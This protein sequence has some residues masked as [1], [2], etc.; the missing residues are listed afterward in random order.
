[1]ATAKQFAKFPLNLGGGDAAGD[2]PMDVLSDSVRETLHTSGGWT[3]NQT[4]NEVKADATGEL[5]TAGGYTALGQLLAS[6][7]YIQ[8]SLRSKFDA[9]DVTWP[10]TTFTHRYAAFWDDTITV[11]ADPLM[12]WIDNGGDVTTSA[13]DLVYQFHATDGIWYFDVT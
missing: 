10:A 2:G 13:T 5:T 3:P 9:A 6:K 11:P 4:T 8:S 7:T 12:S 1:M